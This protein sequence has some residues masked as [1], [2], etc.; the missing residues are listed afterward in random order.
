MKL[1][2][3]TNNEHKLAE[4]RAILNDKFQI[5][6]LRNIGCFEEL[7][8]TTGTIE[9]NSNQ[10]A[11]YVFSKYKIDCFA[12][13]SGLEVPALNNAPGVDSAIYAG[14]Q[15]NHDDNIELLLKNLHGYT[16]RT[17]RFITIISLITSGQCFQFEG[18]L[19]GRILEEKHGDG[20]FGYD[21][22]FLPDGFDRTLAQM[23]MEEKNRISHRAKAVEKLVAFLESY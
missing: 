9:G 22:V 21:P 18:I 15:R 17:A 19:S 8:E 4:V 7:P 16:N 11:Q 3:A 1:C 12:D 20:G 5:L 2:F 6:S 10:K 14:P 13:D 23:T